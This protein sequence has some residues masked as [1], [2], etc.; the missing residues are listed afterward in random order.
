[1]LKTIDAWVQWV[2][3]LHS[4]VAIRESA[5]VYPALLTFHLLA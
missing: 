1:M 5:V 2:D 3:A 4:R